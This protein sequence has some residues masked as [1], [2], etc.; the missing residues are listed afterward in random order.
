MS[1]PGT[2]R[3]GVRTSPSCESGSGP[4]TDHKSG[5]EAAT[6][7]VRS[8]CRVLSFPFSEF[9]TS[10]TSLEDRETAPPA[11]LI[12]AHSCTFAESSSSGIQIERNT[13][14]PQGNT[15]PPRSC[16]RLQRVTA[17]RSL[18]TDLRVGTIGR[19]GRG[20]RSRRPTTPDSPYC[21]CLCSYMCCG[22]DRA[23]D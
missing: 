11:R 16:R 5:A 4:E 3:Q 14:E 8:R 15:A 22:C 7:H 19:S 9:S 2:A 6:V 12:S 23:A 18:G 13:D 20:T 10:C 21:T 17:R 1:L